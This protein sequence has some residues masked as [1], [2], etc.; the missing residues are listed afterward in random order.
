MPEELWQDVRYA[1]RGLRTHPGFA[2][3]AVLSLALGI[4]A[5]TAIFSLIN[6]VLL[7]SVNVSHPEELLQVTMGEQWGLGNP[8]WEQIRDRQDVFSGIFGYGRWAFNL[9]TGGEARNANGYYVSG[10]FF[11]TLGVHALLGRTLTPGDDRRGCAGTAVLSHGFWQR[12]FGGRGDIVGRTISLENHPFEILGVTAP[13]FTGFDVGS[14]VDVLVPFCSEKIIHGE[15]SNLDTRNAWYIRVIGRP[16][17]GISP[18]RATARLKTLAPA[19]LEASLPDKWWLDTYFPH[20]RRTLDTRPADKG[21]SYLRQ[22]YGRPLLILM[23]IA[24][25]VLLIACVNLANLLLARGTARR[26]EFAIR[27]ALGSGGGRLLRQSLAESLLLASI[28]TVAGVLLAKAGTGLLVR[29]LDVFL[30]LTPDARML[31][32]TVGVTVLTALLSGLAPAWRASHVQPQT[33]LTANARGVL[34]SS[35]GRSKF[36]LGGLLVTAQIALSL[37]LVVSAGLLLSTFWKLAWLDPGFERDRVLLASVDLHNGRDAKERRPATYGKML[38][39]L[40][41]LPGVDSAAA[42]DIAPMCGCAYRNELVIEGGAPGSP[43]N[44]LAN[45]N[46]VSDRYFETLGIPFV[47]GRD[48]DGHDTPASRKVAVINQTLARQYFGA[49]NPLGRRYRIRAAG[50]LSDPVEIVGVVKDSKYAALRERIPPTAYSAWSQNPAPDPLMNFE[51][52]AAGGAPAAL[53]ASVQAAIGEVDP[54]VS[55][56]FTTLSA[57]VDESIARERLLAALAGLFGAIALLLAAI[58]LYGIMSYSVTRRRN[59][60]G[61]RMALGADPARVRKMVMSEAALL[62]AIGLVVGLGAALATTRLVASFLYGLTP[63]DPLVLSLAA[64]VLASVAIVAG[65]L[66]ARRASRQNPLVALR[67]E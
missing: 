6:A 50:A 23:A 66:P 62:I 16:K 21:L 67:E 36:G 59:E 33:E 40:R 41:A 31:G 3:V 25:M 63:N 5:N 58:G 39:N 2:S 26:R 43:G 11:E 19:I 7:K 35:G 56:Q 14:I 27:L 61:I 64:G 29:Y 13:G 15:T 9:S 48:F 37:L 18:A 55:Q 4:G 53:S 46:R 57:K 38:D 8:T 24:A 30:D 49:A 28:G 1:L 34:A 51:L 12:E 22:E 10:Q 44:A 17:P 45:L 60:I 32:F 52:R 65:Y 47:A 20:F 54:G 42:S